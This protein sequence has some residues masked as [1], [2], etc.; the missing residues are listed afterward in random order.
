MLLVL[1]T[2]QKQVIVMVECS[3]MCR[4]DLVDLDYLIDGVSISAFVVKRFDRLGNLAFLKV[5]DCSIVLRL[6]LV[7][8][9]I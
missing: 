2:V 9:E 7:D 3:R 1:G 6:E 5:P 8:F 4:N